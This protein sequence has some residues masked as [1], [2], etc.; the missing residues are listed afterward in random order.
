MASPGPAKGS[1][2]RPRKPGGS[3]LSKGKNAGYTKVT[4][5][6]KGAGTQKYEHRVKAGVGKGSKTGGTVVHHVDKTKSNNSKSN[7]KK[8]SRENH[9]TIH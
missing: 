2:G 3:T 7:L 4:V 1:G 8:T 6:P 5:G 9:P